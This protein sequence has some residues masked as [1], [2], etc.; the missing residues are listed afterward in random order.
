MKY[1][2]KETLRFALKTFKRQERRAFAFLSA[3][4]K[5][6]KQTDCRIPLIYSE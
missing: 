4:E 5:K 1:D 3:L 6:K 2:K